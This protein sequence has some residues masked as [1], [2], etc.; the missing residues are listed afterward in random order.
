MSPFTASTGG[1]GAHLFVRLLTI[2]AG[3]DHC[4]N[5]VLSGHEGKFLG[6]TASDDL[7]VYY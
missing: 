3:F 1:N 6:D 7:G 2:A 5:N 4:H